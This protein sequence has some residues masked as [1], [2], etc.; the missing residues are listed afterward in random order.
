[1]STCAAV[2]IKLDAFC[3]HMGVP[4]VT[5]ACPCVSS[6]EL[7]CTAITEVSA[8]VLAGTGPDSGG[9]VLGLAAEVGPGAALSRH[10]SDGCTARLPAHA[11]LSRHTECPS[12]TFLPHASIACVID[13]VGSLCFACSAGCLHHMLSTSHAVCNHQDCK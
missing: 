9:G 8:A 6:P 1:M 13:Y 11:V 4:G 2:W 10:L 12:G 5:P 3:L 7:P